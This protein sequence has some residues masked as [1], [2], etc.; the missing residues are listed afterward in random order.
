VHVAAQVEVEASYGPMHIA[1]TVGGSFDYS[2][3]DAEEHAYQQSHEMVTR[4]VTRVEQRVK[5]S[6]ATRSLQRTT[7]DNKHALENK[8]AQAVVGI[9]RWV[10]KVQRLQLFRYPHRLLLEFEIPEP[11]AYLNW[12]RSQPRGDFLTPE[13][14]PLIRRKADHS[15]LLDGN[16]KSQPLQPDDIIEQ[17][18]QWWVAQYNVMGVSQPPPMRVQISVRLELK[19]QVPAGGGAPGGGGADANSVTPSLTDKSLFD[20]IAPGGSTASQPGVTIPLGYRLQSWTASGYAADTRVVFDTPGYAIIRPTVDVAVGSVTVALARTTALE[21]VNS[22][23]SVKLNQLGPGDPPNP[24][25]AVP[26]LGGYRLAG[27]APATNYDA[28]SPVTGTVQV[29]AHATTTKQC[30]LQVTLNCLRMDDGDAIRR[31]QQ[32]TYEQISA[33]YWALKRQRADEQAAQSIGAGVEIKGDSPARN[34]EVIAEELKRGVIEMLTGENLR[35]RDAM[36]VV[37]LGEAPKVN[38]DLAIATAEEIQFIEQAF[39]WENLTY[40]LYPYFWA[41]Y[42]RWPEL[43]DVT[44]SDPNFARFLR[45]GSAR[46]VVPARPKFENQVCAYVDL[47]VLWGG[48]PVPTVNDP[49]YLSIAAE[50]MA[51][52]SPPDDGEKGRSWE[53]RLPTTLVWL[54]NNNT[55]PKENPSPTLDQPP[56]RV[57][58]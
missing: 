34:K 52:Q 24:P 19:E 37:P 17:T 48:R 40:V 21:T 3:K 49:D 44:L 20:L 15:P 58:P 28:A 35:G 45:S 43:A 9:Y 30:A 41:R 57:G 36:Q 25:T 31:W 11:A 26:S 8:T 39:E 5:T 13:P 56:G 54:D 46:V 29:F 2:Q 1:A 50:I 6:R 16:K 14:V 32:Q 12:R 4:A 47:G 42:E 7:E 23:N 10:D 33:A 27:S 18:Y 22:A 51:Q 55:L 53:V 38:L